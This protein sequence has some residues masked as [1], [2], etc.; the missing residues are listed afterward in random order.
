[1]FAFTNYFRILEIICLV[2][3]IIRFDAPLSDLSDLE[4]G[5]GCGTLRLEVLSP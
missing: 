1:M 4:N 3:S 5:K 2:S